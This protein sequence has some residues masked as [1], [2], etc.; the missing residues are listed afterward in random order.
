VANKLTLLRPTVLEQRTRLEKAGSIRVLQRAQDAASLYE[1]KV[2]DKADSI[3]SST[4]RDDD[5]SYDLGFDFDQLVID[6]QVYRKAL[7]RYVG[8]KKL[9][10]GDGNPPSM[11][12][13]R[14]ESVVKAQ[15]ADF[16]G[17]SEAKIAIPGLTETRSSIIFIA[18][19]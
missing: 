3:L 11:S 16:S 18:T 19:A 17:N 13:R 10:S 2:T 6:S 15:P 12:T 5:T 8:E 7:L 4:L 14:Q 9:T 1:D